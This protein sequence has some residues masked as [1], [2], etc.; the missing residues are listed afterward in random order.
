[1]LKLS[2]AASMLTYDTKTKRFVADYKVMNVVLQKIF[3][4]LD[5][6]LRNGTSSGNTLLVL[7]PCPDRVIRDYQF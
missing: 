4:S 1:V 7:P 6:Q 5:H 2:E 3:G